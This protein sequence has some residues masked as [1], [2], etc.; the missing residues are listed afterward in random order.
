MSAPN[1]YDASSFITNPSAQKVF[2]LLY[3]YKWSVGGI[4][5]VGGTAYYVSKL[6]RYVPV[7]ELLIM[8]AE[9][10]DRSDK[11]MKAILRG[12]EG[13]RILTVTIYPQHM[14]HL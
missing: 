4:I 5:L 13:C 3:R 1:V 7:R 8:I 14:P 6:L 9:S 11:D 10:E 12:G 2:A